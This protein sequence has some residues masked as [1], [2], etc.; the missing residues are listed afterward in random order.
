MRSIWA[1]T[2]HTFAQCL[3][4]KIAVMFIILLGVLLAVLPA[5]MEGDGTL[6]GKIRTF[7]AYGLSSTQML[8]ILVTI[9]VSTAVVSWDIRTKQI[10]TIATKP[11]SRW[12]Y[13]VGRW[14]GV[15]LLDVVLLALAG[16]AIFATAQYLRAGVP[17]NATDHRA[18]ET[19]VFTARRQVKPNPAPI[20]QLVARR[21]T[22]AQ[23]DGRWGE[24]LEELKTITGGDPVRAEQRLRR[25]IRKQEIQKIQSVAPGRTK[26]WGFSGVKVA[27]GGIRGSGL[28]TDWD[29][30]RGLLR[31][32]APTKTIG[33][34]VLD[35]PI[36]IDGRDARVVG[37]GWDFFVAQLDS[38]QMEQMHEGFGEN[39][40]V[41]LITEPIIQISYKLESAARNVP[42]NILKGQW[43]VFNPQNPGVGYTELRNDPP[44]MPATLTV[45]ARAVDSEGNTTVQYRNLPNVP[46]NFATTVSIADED[47]TLLY[48]AGGFEMNF[49]RGLG[50]ILLQLIF[51]AALGVFAGSFTSFPIASLICFAVLPFGLAGEFVTGA[52]K[53]D[54]GVVPSEPTIAFGYIVMKSMKVMFPNLAAMSPGGYLVQGVY[55]PW[56][57]FGWLCA[58][59]LGVQTLA[60]LGLACLIFHF[61]ELARAQV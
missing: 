12:E 54:A 52:V 30:S 60:V 53:L 51:L 29:E 39:R 23:R 7:L 37:L 40:P 61:R 27:A 22:Q 16:S 26:R 48:R 59:T 33:H 3:R 15:V 1:V 24:A 9:F 20:D 49:I 10:F 25:E 31:I 41:Q 4:M 57:E 58:L 5:V 18:V 6:A 19:E 2:R 34:F 17:I 8:L 21:I 47:M 11:V 35:G 13:I 28:V 38:A 32:E 50:L 56:A 14:A 44:G 43:T 36:Q 55:I 45:L 46:A 42:G